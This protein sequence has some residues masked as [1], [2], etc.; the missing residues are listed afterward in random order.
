MQLDR[1]LHSQGFGSRKEVRAL[2]RHGLVSVAG[3]ICENPFAEF[4][5]E[6]LVFTVDGEE[7]RY[8]A[9]AYVMLH[10]P[11]GYEVSQKPKH[12]RSVF[13]LLADP[14]RV[15]GIQAVGRL[16]EDTTGLLILTDDGQLIHRLSSPKHKVPKRYAVTLK[17]PVNEELTQALLAGVVLHDDP[18]PVAAAA[19][20]PSGEYE[21]TL[22]ITSGKYHQVKRMIAAAGNR[23]EALHRTA[24]GGLALPADLPAGEWRWISGTDLERLRSV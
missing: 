12:H 22:T 5:P 10:K 6:N 2:V 1:I 7:W 9:Q 20:E 21:L 23:V 19:V 15:R 14:L 17:H 24:V 13:E 8:H 11:S 16:D 4:E 3:E 18:E